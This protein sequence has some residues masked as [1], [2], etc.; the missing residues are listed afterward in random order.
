MEAMSSVLCP[1]H[2][3]NAVVS[4]GSTLGQKRTE[5]EGGLLGERLS[6]G[7]GVCWGV[8]IVPRGSNV[9]G[10]PRDHREADAMERF[11]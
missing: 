6:W 3:S 9:C 11:V 1:R 10:P 2:N 5:R 8:L 7:P 4:G